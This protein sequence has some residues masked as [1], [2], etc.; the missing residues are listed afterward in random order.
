MLEYYFVKNEGNVLTEM[1]D[2]EFLKIVWFMQLTVSNHIGTVSNP[3]FKE[4]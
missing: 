2:C 3:I 1:S 4:I